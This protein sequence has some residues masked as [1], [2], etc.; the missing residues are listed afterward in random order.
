MKNQHKEHTGEHAE[1]VI[2]IERLVLSAQSENSSEKSY[3]NFL[4][5][6]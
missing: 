1:G 5:S 6:P 2:V 3:A 4:V